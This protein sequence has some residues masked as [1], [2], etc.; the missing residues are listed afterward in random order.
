LEWPSCIFPTC[1][2]PASRSTREEET[3]A[4]PKMDLSHVG[5]WWLRLTMLIWLFRICERLK[6][7]LRG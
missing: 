5:I 1:V 7:K 2:L 4:K 3:M 6:A